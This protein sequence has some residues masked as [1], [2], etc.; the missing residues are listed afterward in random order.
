LQDEYSLINSFG[1][2]NVEALLSRD[3]R[4]SRMCDDLYRHAAPGGGDQSSQL[5]AEFE[6]SSHDDIMQSRKTKCLIDSYE[7]YEQEYNGMHELAEYFD[8]PILPLPILILRMFQSFV[9]SSPSEEGVSIL[10]DV[11]DLN[12]ALRSLLKELKSKEKVSEETVRDS[13]GVL[14]YQFNLPSSKSASEPEVADHKSKGRSKTPKAQAAAVSAEDPP[15][16]RNSH[17]DRGSR[18]DGGRGGGGG[19]KDYFRDRSASRKPHATHCGLCGKDDHT[20]AGK[21]P[22]IDDSNWVPDRDG[23]YQAIRCNNCQNHGH[24]AHGCPGTLR[25]DKLLA[26]RKKVFL[27]KERKEAAANLAAAEPAVPNPWKQVDHWGSD[28]DSDTGSDTSEG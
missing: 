20:D 7:K 18:G 16:G 27:E 14:D 6:T 5:I 13:L 25:A 26:H 12:P 17:R 24:Y 21:C 23:V 2:L 11:P 10:S 19:G 22:Q 4:V 3:D 9:Q 28:T 1:E 15:R 8:Q